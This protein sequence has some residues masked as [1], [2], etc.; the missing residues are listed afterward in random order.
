[1]AGF[2]VHGFLR[3]GERGA[4]ASCPT[5]AFDSSGIIVQGLFF[6][7]SSSIQEAAAQAENPLKGAAEVV[8]EEAVENGVSAAVGIAENEGHMVDS[9]IKAGDEKIQQLHHVERHPTEYKDSHYHQHKSCDLL[10]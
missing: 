8:G 5:P 1:V 9:G 4:Y 7:T 10:L 3:A 6:G 2:C